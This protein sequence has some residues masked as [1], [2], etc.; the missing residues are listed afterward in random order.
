MAFASP[1]KPLSQ[2]GFHRLLSPTAAVKVSP[3]CLGGMN[4]GDAWKE[5]MGECDKQTAFQILDYFYGNGGN[6]IDTA[7]NYQDGESEKWIGEWMEERG[8]RDEIVIATK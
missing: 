5:F 2:L 4:F 1:S 3:L 8:V 6:F 7:N